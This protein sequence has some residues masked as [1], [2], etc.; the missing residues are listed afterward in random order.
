MAI[1]KSAERI[2]GTIRKHA[3]AEKNKEGEVIV[4]SNTKISIT[5]SIVVCTK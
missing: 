3:G 2:M 4:V 5:V 1:K